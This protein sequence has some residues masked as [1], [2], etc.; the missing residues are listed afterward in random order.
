MRGGS[1]EHGTPADGYAYFQTVMLTEAPMRES[2][3]P[4]LNVEQALR[5]IPAFARMTLL[6][7]GGTRSLDFFTC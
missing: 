1:L 2:G 6:G 7:F 5:W 3:N 4:L